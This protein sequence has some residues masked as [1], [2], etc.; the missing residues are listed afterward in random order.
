[1][2]ETAMASCL[3]AQGL[4]P[5]GQALQDCVDQE[6][7]DIIACGLL[8]DSLCEPLSMECE[9]LGPLGQCV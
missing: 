6:A 4:C 9:D 1:M 5:N 3:E 2:A 8:P 7:E